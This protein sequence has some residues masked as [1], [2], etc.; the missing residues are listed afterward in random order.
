MQI[1]NTNI[2]ELHSPD[3]M[4]RIKKL[5]FLFLIVGLWILVVGI[6]LVIFFES[7]PITGTLVSATGMS[8]AWFGYSYK[9]KKKIE[10]NEIMKVGK[11]IFWIGAGFLLL[12]IV[13]ESVPQSY[14]LTTLFTD[15]EI[16]G[17]GFIVL[18]L[19]ASDVRR[20]I[21]PET[22]DRLIGRYLTLIGIAIFLSAFIFVAFNL[23]I[24]C[25]VCL[26]LGFIIVVV[27]NLMMALGDKPVDHRH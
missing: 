15:Y 17:V 13:L 23:F 9:P 22:G 21:F 8:I 7:I 20:K 25:V 3:R 16:T 24:P 4:D 12:A 1:L 5:N 27:G 6:Y 10:L 14:H 19:G 26:G 18:F 11:I 2:K